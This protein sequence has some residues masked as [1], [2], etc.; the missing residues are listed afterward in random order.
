MAEVTAQQELAM[1]QVTQIHEQNQLWVVSERDK[2][3]AEREV[4]RQMTTR[5]DRALENVPQF[6]S[7]LI[8]WAEAKSQEKRENVEQ[9]VDMAYK[10]GINEPIIEIRQNR[11]RPQALQRPV[12]RLERATSL[13]RDEMDKM[14]DD[15]LGGDV[16]D[17]GKAVDLLNEDKGFYR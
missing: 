6:N 2:L 10:Q 8:K 17:F 1:K 4:L 15:I 3:N 11:E 7:N 16:E 12:R 9:V 5:I 14:L 13:K